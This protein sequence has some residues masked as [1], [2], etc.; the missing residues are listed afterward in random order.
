MSCSLSVP[1]SCDVLINPAHPDASGIHI[2]Y[3]RP[4]TFDPRLF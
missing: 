2:V 1:E 3:Y 4:W